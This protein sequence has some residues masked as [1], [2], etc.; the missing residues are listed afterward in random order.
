MAQKVGTT[1]SKGLLAGRIFSAAL[2]MTPGSPPDFP[3]S[4]AVAAAPATARA[5]APPTMAVFTRKSRRE[6]LSMLSFS[7][8]LL[9]VFMNSC[10]LSFSR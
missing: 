7:M 3:A 10:S 9:S 2:W 8:P 6:D 1:F 5:E 4:D